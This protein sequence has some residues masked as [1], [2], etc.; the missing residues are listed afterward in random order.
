M[1]IGCRARAEESRC[2]EEPCVYCGGAPQEHATPT[3]RP[4]SLLAGPRACRQP[5]QCGA[6]PC[7][8]MQAPYHVCVPCRQRMVYGMARTVDGQTG[9]SSFV[10]LPSQ[11]HGNI[12]REGREAYLPPGLRSDL[13]RASI[14]DALRQ[15]RDAQRRAGGA[16]VP[17]DPLRGL[18]CPFRRVTSESAGRAARNRPS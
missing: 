4:G 5:W 3:D 7:T 11:G 14:C 6:G 13:R 8:L 10:Q 15:T 12:R 17:P 16:A 2:Q 9:R 1:G 18:A